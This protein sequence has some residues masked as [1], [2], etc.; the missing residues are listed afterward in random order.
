MK[1]KDGFICSEVC[2][3]VLE[4]LLL[5]NHIALPFLKE[6]NLTEP[7]DYLVAPWKVVLV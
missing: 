6:A 2:Q 3:R 1:S 4:T 5:E 7:D